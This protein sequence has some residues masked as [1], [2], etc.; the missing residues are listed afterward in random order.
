MTLNIRPATI[1]DM[2][3]VWGLVHELAVYEKAPEQVITT[4]ESMQRDGFGLDKPLFQCIV[5]EDEAKIIVGTAIFYVGYSTWKGKIIYLDDLIVTEKYR[6]FGLGKQLIDR[7]LSIAKEQ[8]AMQVRWHVL[9][10]NEPAI[11]F[12][13]KLGA[14][15]DGEWITCKVELAKNEQ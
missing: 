9:D 5:A 7:L 8:N 10:W 2:P 3:A 13:K 12:Y 6:R 1:A 4:P 15:L 11:Q 14:N